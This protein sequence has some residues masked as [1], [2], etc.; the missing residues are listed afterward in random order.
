MSDLDFPVSIVL[1]VGLAAA[2][3]FRIFLPTLIVS[4]AAYSGHLSLDERFAWLA[5]Q[6]A[7]IM[8]SV[9]TV[10]EILAYYIPAVDNLL[11]TL[12]TPAALV[13]GTVVSAAVMTD[14]PP[15]VKWTAA[16]GRRRRRPYAR[17]DRR[18]Q[19]EIHP[20]DGRCR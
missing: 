1:G 18:A 2:T 9:A 8:L 7:L 5:T 16:G 19:G 10:L 4:V 6:S 11:D 14:V 13:A 12:A 15:I 3:G 17:R 20:P